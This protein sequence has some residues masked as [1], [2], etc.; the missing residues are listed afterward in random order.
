MIDPF[1]EM[2]ELYKPVKIYAMFSGG[3]DSLCATH[4]AMERGAH[5]VCHIRT[6]IG[7]TETTQFVIDTC[8]SH[9][10]PLIIKDPPV[11]TYEQMVLKYGFPGPGAHLYPYSWL[12]DRAIR[13]LVAEA[14]TKRMDR[15]ALVTGVRNK[16]S[17]RRMGFVKPIYKEDARIWTA[18]LYD[19]DKLDQAAYMRK[20][21]LKQNPV[22]KVVGFSGECFCGAF[23]QQPQEVELEMLAKNF[24]YLH[25]RIVQ[26]QD[27]AR[28]LGVHCRWGIRPPPKRCDDQYDLPFM[29]M[30]VNCHAR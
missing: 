16:E 9:G 30:C 26:L 8:E 11:L 23:A 28:E 17:A 7:L 18:P 5:G 15:V 3:N 1:G 14:K 29:P 19:T 24:P 20:H 27:E 25:R 13:R 21:G 22:I 6:G 4:F 10:W 12:K 2:Q